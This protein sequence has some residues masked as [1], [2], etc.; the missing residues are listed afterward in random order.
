M[1]FNAGDGANGSLPAIVFVCVNHERRD[2]CHYTTR[3]LC[4]GMSRLVRFRSSLREEFVLCLSCRPSQTFKV[5]FARPHYTVDTVPRSCSPSFVGLLRYSLVCLSCPVLLH[6]NGLLCGQAR[7][8][9]LEPLDDRDQKDQI[10]APSD[11][12]VGLG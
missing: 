3:V 9:T 7:S 8:R 5:T 1:L 11:R 4:V 12:C 6:W 10:A 2:A